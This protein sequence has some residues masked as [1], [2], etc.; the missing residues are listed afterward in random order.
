MLYYKERIVKAVRDHPSP[1]HIDKLR[2]EHQA[3]AKLAAES[4]LVPKAFHGDPTFVELVLAK[5]TPAPSLLAEKN[6]ESVN[7][8]G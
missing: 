6:N 1:R 8:P 2:A 7:G 3:Q 5:N 4:G